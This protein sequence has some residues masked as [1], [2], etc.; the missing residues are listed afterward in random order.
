MKLLFVLFALFVVG[1]N[2]VK[3]IPDNFLGTWELGNDFRSS[4][5]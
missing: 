3:T 4:I 1:T 5:V 2:A